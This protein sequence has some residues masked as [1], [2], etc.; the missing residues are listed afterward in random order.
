MVT[1]KSRNCF[2]GC[3]IPSPKKSKG[4]K[5]TPIKT[6]TIWPPSSSRDK[7][8]DLTIRIVAKQRTIS[9]VLTFLHYL[10]TITTLGFHRGS[11]DKSKICDWIPHFVNFRIESRNIRPSCKHTFVFF[12]RWNL[13]APMGCSSFNFCCLFIYDHHLKLTLKKSTR[14][15]QRPTVTHSPSGCPIHLL[16]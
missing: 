11:W 4:Q 13:K 15:S 3:C 1:T 2:D 10:E 12:R 6:A 8:F 16:W 9:S 7:F 5:M 14:A